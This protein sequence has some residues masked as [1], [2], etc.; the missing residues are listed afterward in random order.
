MYMHPYDATNYHDDLEN[1]GATFRRRVESLLDRT[2]VEFVTANDVRKILEI[3][4]RK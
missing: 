3:T 2:D 4:D 1:S